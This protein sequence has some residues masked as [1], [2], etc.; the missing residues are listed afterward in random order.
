MLN[1]HPLSLYRLSALTLTSKVLWRVPPQMGL[2]I[3][4]QA[5]PA[6]GGQHTTAGN[7]PRFNKYSARALQVTT[8][9]AESN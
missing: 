9:R 7:D 1:P 2:S 5:N 6:Y 8:G 4:L 3:P